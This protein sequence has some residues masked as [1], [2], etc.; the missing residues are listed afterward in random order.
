M[1]KSPFLEIDLDCP[2]PI[3]V[4]VP[5]PLRERSVLSP[6]ERA[7]AERIAPPGPQDATDTAA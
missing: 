5:L 3:T 1:K 6:L 4:I 2:L 7:I